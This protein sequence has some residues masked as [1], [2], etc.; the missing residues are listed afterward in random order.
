MSEIDLYID[1][2]RTR[3]LEHQDVSLCPALFSKHEFFARPVNR[4]HPMVR[5]CLKAVYE[6]EEESYRYLYASAAIVR[7]RLAI[8][9]YTAGRVEAMWHEARLD[10]VKLIAGF[11]ASDRLAVLSAITFADW[12]EAIQARARGMFDGG[13]VPHADVRLEEIGELCDSFASLALQLDTLMPTAVWVDLS[14]VFHQHGFDHSRTLV[15]NLEAEQILHDPVLDEQSPIIILTEGRTDQRV[16][17]AAL[18]AFYPE[19]AEAYQFIEFDAFRVEGGASPLAKMVKAFAGIRIRSRMLAI[20]DNDAAGAEA[21][22]SLKP[23]RL[24]ENLRTMSLPDLRLARSYPTEGPEGLRRMD[25]NG[26]ACAI[27][28]YLGR[29]SLTDDAGRLRHVRWTQYAERVHRYQGEVNGKAEVVEK[30]LRSLDSEPK[31][32]R[33]KYPEMCVLLKA[34]FDAFKS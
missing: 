34:I 2:I 15:E 19:F 24:P 16:I 10:Y 30:F 6:G 13:E 26:R 20:F 22:L 12:K 29:A 8:Q 7:E 33:R 31:S 3:I 18:R 32:L 17:S 27:E 11:A 5:T 25:L 23:I 21:L 4:S 1:E 9:G 28:M 14:S